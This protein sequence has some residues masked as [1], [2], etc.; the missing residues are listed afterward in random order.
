M[1]SQKTNI[2]SR[3]NAAPERASSLPNVVYQPPKL[4]QIVEIIDLMGT[5]ATRVREDNAGDWTGASGSQS[6][7]SS[8]TGDDTS[9]RDQAI[10]KAPSIPVMQKQLIKHLE[11]EMKTIKKQVRL[12]SSSKA[13]GSAYLLNELYKKLRRM[14]E[15]VSQILGASAEVIKRFYVSVF[16]DHQPMVVRGGSLAPS[17]E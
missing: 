1:V 3:I 6:G 4:T 12:V 2:E 11:Q 7:A 16:I 14:S 9:T 17:E 8:G 13:R 5:V 10:A 15:L